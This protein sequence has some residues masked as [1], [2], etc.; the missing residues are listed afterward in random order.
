MNIPMPAY[1]LQPPI[2]LPG[3]RLFSRAIIIL[4]RG[5]LMTERRKDLLVLTLL[6]AVLI[7]FFGRILFTDKIIRAPDIINEFYWGVE[8][9]RNGTFW[10]VIRIRLTPSWNLFIN[11]GFTDEGGGV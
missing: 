8:G 11:S 2:W 9:T 5:V 6:L 10:D 1:W 3:N 4:I 7:I